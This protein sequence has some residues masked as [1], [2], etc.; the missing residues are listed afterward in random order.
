MSLDLDLYCKHCNQSV[1]SF[2]IT[3]N[4]NKMAMEV[5]MYEAMWRPEELN[6]NKIIIKEKLKNGIMQLLDN[7][8]KFKKM[9]PENGWGTY[10][11][12]LK[13]ATGYLEALNEHPECEIRADR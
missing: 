12:L 4:L 11:G 13:V 1:K 6:Y 9:N 7:P 2:N 3:H 5:G 8:V 10:E